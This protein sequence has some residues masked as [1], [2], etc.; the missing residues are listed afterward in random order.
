[1]D[2]ASLGTQPS[3]G[4]WLNDGIGIVRQLGVTGVRNQITTTLTTCCLAFLHTF[5]NL[6]TDVLGMVGLPEW[7]FYTIALCLGV[8]LLVAGYKYIYKLLFIGFTCT[9]VT[10][11]AMAWGKLNPNMPLTSRPLPWEAMGVALLAGLYGGWKLVIWYR[12]Q[13]LTVAAFLGF[14]SGGA[15]GFSLLALLRSALE[16]CDLSPHT[17][18]IDDKYHTA[19]VALHYP[20]LSD[21]VQCIMGYQASCKP[22]VVEDLVYLISMVLVAIWLFSKFKFALAFVAE[23]EV[24]FANDKA[25]LVRRFAEWLGKGLYLELIVLSGIL[26]SGT[27]Q[28]M[29][30]M[31]GDALFD[32]QLGITFVPWHDTE[33]PLK[34]VVEVLTYTTTFATCIGYIYRHY[35]FLD[36]IVTSFIGA[37]LTTASLDQLGH[38][39]D[40]DEGLLFGLS[41][42][43]NWMDMWLMAEKSDCQSEAR[44]DETSHGGAVFGVLF[45]FGFLFQNRDE[46]GASVGY[47][48]SW[49]PFFGGST[50]DKQT[51]SPPK[52]MKAPRKSAIEAKSALVSKYEPRTSLVKASRPLAPKPTGE[53]TRRAPVRSPASEAPPPAPVSSEGGESLES[54]QE[55]T[56]EE[57]SALPV[58]V[59]RKELKD[60]GLN[61]FGSKEV[62][63]QRLV[64]ASSPSKRKRSDAEDA[65]F[66]DKK[67]SKRTKTAEAQKVKRKRA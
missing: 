67:E 51:Q 61:C 11:T 18:W 33:M 43:S 16:V 46:I 53:L 36:S 55:W 3:L 41:K 24:L 19:R 45:A 14:L 30:Y 29:R 12:K 37:L 66:S 23:V 34:L 40:A 2:F 15:V 49:L 28:V 7:I 22:L 35:S 4:A 63:V 17:K 10:I 13:V 48:L 38:I 5:F 26:A 27:L 56:K 64:E 44:C 57:A 59:L 62:L 58:N 54:E 6:A 60:Q 65:D 1:M 21:A 31:G 32:I 9:T 25:S 8:L 47:I 52:A 20:S 39:G 42:L 50:D